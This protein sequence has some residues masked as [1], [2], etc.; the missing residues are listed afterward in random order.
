MAI[1]CCAEANSENHKGKSEPKYADEHP[2]NGE[3]LDE[4]VLLL[5]PSRV[6]LVNMDG[7]DE[8]CQDS[9]PRMKGYNIEQALIEA[10]QNAE[11]QKYGG[12]P[13]PKSDGRRVFPSGVDG[14]QNKYGCHGQKPGAGVVNHISGTGHYFWMFLV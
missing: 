9:K 10:P 5:F 14:S 6:D 1:N 11:K 3:T 2:G 7:D 13:D 12:N 8:A 4:F